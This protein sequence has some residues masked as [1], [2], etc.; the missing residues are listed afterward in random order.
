MWWYGTSYSTEWHQSNWG[1]ESEVAG[2]PSADAHSNN[3]V[4]V[5]YRSNG[6]QLG[7]WW[8]GVNYLTEWTQK[9]W[10]AT[11]TLGGDPSAAAVASG[12][13]AIYYGAIANTKMWQW[14]IGSS[15]TLTEVGAW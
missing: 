1:V 8:Y 2:D 9:N 11:K 10:G 7:Q 15:G 6:G 4:Y 3:N 12:G 5:Y 13:D 14:S